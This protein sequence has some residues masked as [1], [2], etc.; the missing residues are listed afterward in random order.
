[1]KQGEASAAAERFRAV[2]GR[3]VVEEDGDGDCD[4]PRSRDAGPFK[5]TRAYDA[6]GYGC[7]ATI[8][9]NWTAVKSRMRQLR[10]P[11]TDPRATFTQASWSRPQL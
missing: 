8:K 1:M 11:V 9:L 3:A 2:E 6:R 7:G 5:G 10:G 4:V